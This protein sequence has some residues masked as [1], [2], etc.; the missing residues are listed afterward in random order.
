[1]FF[2]SVHHILV[3]FL[4]MYIATNY[5]QELAGSPNR[6]F[7]LWK[8]D[9]SPPV[10]TYTSH[11]HMGPPPPHH[12]PLHHYPDPTSPNHPHHPPTQPPGIAK[13]GGRDPPRIRL[14]GMQCAIRHAIQ[15]EIRYAQLNYWPSATLPNV[16]LE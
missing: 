9:G 6:S 1:M 10:A 4:V 2:K 3:D 14:I 12:H 8:T 5:L 11:Q 15:Q 16:S 7:Y 13:K